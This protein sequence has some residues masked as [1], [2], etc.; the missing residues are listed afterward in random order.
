M[1][2]AL[3]ASLVKRLP[4][5]T[6]V[7]YLV[8][9]FLIGPQVANWVRPHP[10]ALSNVLEHLAEAAVLISLFAAGLK[11]RLPLTDKRWVAPVR[12]ALVSM[13]LTVGLVTLVGFYW[14]HLPLGAAVILGAVL[15]PTDPVLASDVQVENPKDYDPLRF[16][17]TAEAGLN[18]GTAFP[19]IML[20]LGLLGVHELGEAGWRWLTVDVVWAVLG[21]LAIGAV[22]GM[23]VAR[24]V[25]YLRKVHREAVG[26]DDY[27]ALG[28]LALAYGL[29]L[30]LHTY[31]FMAVFAA[32]LALRHTERLLSEKEEPAEGAAPNQTQTK[33][34]HNVLQFNEQVERIAELGLVVLVG[35]VL[36]NV[37]WDNRIWWFFPLMFA[38]V[39]P[40]AIYL[41]LLG[42]KGMRHS[43]P[44]ISWFGIRGIGSIFYLMYALNHGVPK[45]LAPILLSFTLYTVAFSILIHGSTVTP[46][47]RLYAKG[48]SDGEES[49]KSAH[50]LQ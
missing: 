2:M 34:A 30:T 9:G 1:G 13:T 38:V 20:G 17:L 32:G 29:A 27:L 5:S 18:D 35:A 6:S 28:L 33:M 22:L 39:R 11:L 25:V 49:Q 3:F 23:S 10:L 26:T 42:M 7:I 19:F 31:G 40:M 44:Y 4:T 50:S 41:G 12:L 46:L 36:A 14:L 45:E 15:A 21:G 24:L 8:V 37:P 48:K 43:K 16:S 47:S